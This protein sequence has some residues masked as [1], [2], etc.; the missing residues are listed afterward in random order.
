MDANS[1]RGGFSQGVLQ[2][3]AKKGHATTKRKGGI[4]FDTINYVDNLRY[5]VG[6]CQAPTSTKRTWEYD[7]SHPFQCGDWTIVHNGVLTNDPELRKTIEGGNDNPVDTSTIAML[8]NQN[9]KEFGVMNLEERIDTISRTLSELRGTFALAMVYL[10][11]NA[12]YLARQ[13]SILHTNSK[14]DFS[15]IKGNDDE[16]YDVVP[17]GLILHLQ[18]KKWVT[19]GEFKS[20]SPF[21]FI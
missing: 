1:T 14:G 4:D 19:A 8:L 6:H 18:K 7:T 2:L 13:G 20:S 10:P 3:K 16:T 15:T 5:L 9:S 12:V 17:E 21:L 11:R